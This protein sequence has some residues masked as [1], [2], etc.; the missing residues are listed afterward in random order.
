M[1]ITFS[2]LVEKR[3]IRQCF[4]KK[5]EID[6]NGGSLAMPK[7]GGPALREVNLP[8]DAMIMTE[9]KAD[10]ATG[11]GGAYFT[12]ENLE[13]KKKFIVPEEDQGKLYFLEFEGIYMNATVWVN[14]SYVGK[15]PFGYSDF[16]L[17]I[18]DYLKYG[19]ENEVKV[20]VK[21]Q[22]QPNSRWY[23]GAGI[24]RNVKLIIG[25]PLHIKMDGVKI[26]VVDIESELATVEIATDIE[27][28]G[29]G[30]QSGYVVTQLRDTKGEVVANE[31]TK[32]N[33]NSHNSLTIR[34]KLYV[35]KPELWDMDHPYLYNCES[36]ILV[37]NDLIDEDSN[38]FGI[39]N[40]QL[41][42]LHGLRINGRSI[43]LK[44]GCIHHDN[45]VIGAATFAD[46]EERRV[47]ELKAAGY[48][49]IR[50][51]HNPISKA[52]LDACDKIGLLVMDEFTDVWT[53]TKC[54]YDYGCHFTEWWEHDVES[55]VKK[56]FNHPS[57]IIYSIGNEIPEVGSDI[58]ASWGRKIAEKIR[59][60]DKT[61][62][63]TNG[64]NVMLGIKD[65][66]GEILSSLGESNPMA[67]I[68][69]I[70][71]S[72]SEMKEKMNKILS[73]PIV[74]TALEESCGIL[75]IVGYNYA[76]ERY[77]KDHEN[78]E[79]RIIVGTETAPASLDI[80]WEIVKNNNYIIGDFCWT[81]WDYLGETGIGHIAYDDDKN[82]NF[83]GEYPWIAAYCADFDIL[84]YR[85]PISYWREII[86]GG[87]K[88]I[89]YIAVQR[90]ERYGQNVFPGMWS[91]T[92]TIASWTW[93]GFEGEGAVVEVYS[94]AEEVEIIINGKSKGK[95]PV[96]DEF[97]KFYCKWDTFYEAGIIEAVAYIDG[98]EVGRHK[99]VTAGKPV[100]RV[101]KEC[102]NIRAGT[103]D[104]CFVNIEFT[105]KNGVLCTSTKKKINICVEGAANLQGSGSSN[106]RTIENY[107]D[108]VHE[109]FDGRALA[110]VRA[111]EETG[112]ATIKVTA[113]G[114]KEVIVEIPVV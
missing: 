26:T 27:F 16:H 113:D 85:R 69:E 25:N 108:T 47:R 76:A 50:S 91:W 73:H 45:G 72:M 4:N 74:D 81:A 43:K 6:K 60:I 111:G 90:L 61:R 44:G 97:K 12:P 110:V 5:W 54:D 1:Q 112:M 83:Y 95:K 10:N 30:I 55:M 15:C 102:E 79:N 70:N 99:L 28:E 42:T 24:Y 93:P 7:F 23:T 71:Q 39:R 64:I 51:A 65:H 9:R 13:Y 14:G 49:S 29:I 92:D 20:F 98:I 52:M 89:P 19:Q 114:F 36:K 84:G 101:R 46:A 107:F 2:Y 109:T 82:E 41:D 34:Q 68:G 53:Q 88:H 62:Y 33:I 35:Q 11:G 18:S 31:K 38:S 59:S 58:G 103:N 94:D 77:E 96:G 104:L 87:R 3:M 48:N 8:Y 22:S 80:N 66:M 32:F 67:N 78:F 40:L 17:Q 86:W 57:V 106:P 63:I 75:D 100:L 37:D 105:D 56:D 21:N